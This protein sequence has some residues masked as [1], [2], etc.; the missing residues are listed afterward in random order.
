MAGTTN[1]E[2]D[3]LVRAIFQNSRKKQ[4]ALLYAAIEKHPDFTEPGLWGGFRYHG[5]DRPPRDVATW[6]VDWFQR[7]Y[8]YEAREIERRFDV[9]PERPPAAGT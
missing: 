5:N 1:R 8:P 4:E 2:E 3:Q 6:L 9:P 7:N